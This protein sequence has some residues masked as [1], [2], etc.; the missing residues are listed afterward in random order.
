M[1]YLYFLL[2]LVLLASCSKENQSSKSKIETIIC[3]DLTKPDFKI[4]LKKK[5][6]INYA[7]L[8]CNMLFDLNQDSKGNVYLA[9]IIKSR[10]MVFDSKGKYLKDIGRRGKG[11]GEFTSL[12]SIAITNDTLFAINQGSQKVSLFDCKDS[13]YTFIKEIPTNSSIQFLTAYGKNF[14]A[15]TQGMD[16]KTQKVNFSISMFDRNFNEIARLDSNTIDFTAFQNPKFDFMELIPIFAG[17]QNF[18]FI[19]KGSRDKYLISAF[20]NQGEMIYKIKRPFMKIPINKKELEEFNK[21]IQ[22]KSKGKS[23]MLNAEYKLAIL[24]L[25]LDA[26]NRLWVQKTV[27]RERE[28]FKNKDCYFDIYENGKLLNTLHFSGITGRDLWDLEQKVFIRNNTLFY[29]NG[30]EGLLDV[31]EIEN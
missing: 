13:S 18:A 23:K 27:N 3:K 8:G 22:E 28:G 11:P 7:E 14:L 6:T 21:F 4:D 19:T 20:N 29:M 15:Y 9:D 30:A 17:N 26:K 5:F 12:N 31:Y 24:A 25:H 16:T 2:A 1:R 10:V